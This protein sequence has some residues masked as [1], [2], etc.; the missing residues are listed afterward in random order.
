[1]TNILITL[2]LS[3][4]IM[5]IMA[6]VVAVPLTLIQMAEEWWDKRRRQKEIRKEYD[7]WYDR[8]LSC[9]NFG[10]AVDKGKAAAMCVVLRVMEEGENA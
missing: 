9:D 1:M 5:L 3:F 4:P 7:K 8:Y 2:L 6:F 10:G